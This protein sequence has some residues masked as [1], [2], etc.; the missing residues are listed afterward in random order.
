MTRVGFALLP[1]RVLQSTC[2]GNINPSP[3][4]FTQT[5]GTRTDT[6]ILIMTD[7]GAYSMWKGFDTDVNG[8]GAWG[9]MCGCG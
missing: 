2:Y 8:I 4:T 6:E 9:C 7:G 1:L 5:L 3:E